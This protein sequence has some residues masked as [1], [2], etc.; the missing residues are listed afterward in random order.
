MSVK[1]ILPKA[2]I[3]GL[4]SQKLTIEEEKVF[5]NINP[6]GFILFERNC[7]NVKQT[8]M[9]IQNLKRIVSHNFPLIYIVL[10]RLNLYWS[11]LV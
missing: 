1:E 4:K 10:Q 8:K 5:Q 2:I 11:M 6:L 9:L 3:F 7:K